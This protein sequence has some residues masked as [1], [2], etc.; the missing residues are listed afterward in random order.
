MTSKVEYAEKYC[1]ENRKVFVIG[2]VIVGNPFPVIEHPSTMK[3]LGKSINPGYQSH[4]T[5]GIFHLFSFDSFLTDLFIIILSQKNRI[6]DGRSISTAF[7]ITKV[8]QLQE[9]W[10][11]DELVVHESQTYPSYIVYY[12]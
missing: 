5:I 9:K 8:E 6:V 10:V 3:Y 2:F 12:K 11:A 4:F 7:P 1:Q